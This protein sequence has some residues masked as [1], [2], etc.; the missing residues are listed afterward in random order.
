MNDE[1][2]RIAEEN[3]FSV[4]QLLALEALAEESKI[5]LPGDVGG[6]AFHAG[7]IGGAKLSTQLFGNT[8]VFVEGMGFYDV[9]DLSGKDKGKENKRSQHHIT[10]SFGLNVTI[11][12]EGRGLVDANSINFFD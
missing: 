4:S 10:L 5:L 1:I 7:P 11:G 9:T 8:R 2:K 12:G 3:E 6:R